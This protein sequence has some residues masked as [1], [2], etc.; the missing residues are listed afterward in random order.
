ME[1]HVSSFLRVS[2]ERINIFALFVYWF[3]FNHLEFDHFFRPMWTRIDYSVWFLPSNVTTNHCSLWCII[4][5]VSNHSVK[6][7]FFHFSNSCVSTS[8]HREDYQMCKSRLWE[9]GLF[10]KTKVVEIFAPRPVLVILLNT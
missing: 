1:F 2:W 7:I 5:C 3:P 10:K 6:L 8:W 9:I 4:F